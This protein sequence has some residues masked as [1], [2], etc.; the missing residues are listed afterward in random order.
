MAP[1]FQPAGAAGG[2]FQ[3][4]DAER[5]SDRET[6]LADFHPAFAIPAS[7]EFLEFDDEESDDT[8][9]DEEPTNTWFAVDEAVAVFVA[10]RWPEEVPLAG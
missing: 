9:E 3:R 5:L 2:G 8:K 7:Q 4:H 1:L 6:D 10:L